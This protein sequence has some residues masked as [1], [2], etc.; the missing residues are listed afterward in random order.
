M[1]DKIH[2]SM[3]LYQGQHLCGKYDLLYSTA[4]DGANQRLNNLMALLIGAIHIS[5][6]P[7]STEYEIINCSDEEHLTRGMKNKS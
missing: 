1:R 4:A 3:E 7:L 2:V 5:K 6:H